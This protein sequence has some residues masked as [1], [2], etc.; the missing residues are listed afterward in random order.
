MSGA[1]TTINPLFRKKSLDQRIKGFN[2]S[3][4]GLERDIDDIN[5]IIQM[6]TNK[7]ENRIPRQEQL[8]KMKQN[9]KTYT[10]ARDR[11]LK[12][13]SRLLQIQSG[14]RRSRRVSRKSKKTRKM[15]KS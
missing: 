2:T 12:E 11:D 8:N 3:I 14:S 9:L 1:V 5:E 15:R 13:L 10:N 7:N 4:E 6:G